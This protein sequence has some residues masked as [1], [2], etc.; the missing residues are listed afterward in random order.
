MTPRPNSRGGVLPSRL[1]CWD[2]FDNVGSDHFR[3]D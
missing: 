1:G 2:D 3:K